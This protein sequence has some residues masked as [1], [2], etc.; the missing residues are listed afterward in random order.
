MVNGK[1]VR[2]AAVSTTLLLAASAC[3][4]SDDGGGGGDS[5]GGGGGGDEA[6]Q[7]NVY[8]SDGNMG[9]ALGEKFGDPGAIAG[10][11]G[12][13]PLT[14]LT[15]DF[16]SRLLEIDP[17]LIDFNY[18]AETYDAVVVAALAAEQARTNQATVFGPFV[19]GITSGG[20]K[21]TDFASCLAIIQAGGDVDFDG[22]SGPLAFTE[23]GEPA[24]ASF[25]ILTFGED[26]LVDNDLT[27]YVLGGDEANASTVA[28]PAAP[29]YATPPAGAPLVVGTLLPLTGNLAF[30]G[31]P[32]VAAAKLVIQDINAAGGALGQPVT[33]I[34]TDSGDT[35]TD[36]A[37]VSVDRLLQSGA[38]VIVGAAS[39]GVSKTVI[40]K[41]TG[42]GVMQI[43]PANTSDEFT[44][45]NDNGLYFR[46][47]P[48]DVLQAK[49]LSD[50]ILDDGNT[51]VSIIA[52]NDPYGTGLASN[53]RD[54]LISA[55]LSEESVPEV[56]IYDPAATSYRTEVGEMADFNPDAI[57]VIG[58]DE[59]SKIIEEMNAQGIGPAA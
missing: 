56:I 11:T 6:K 20:E 41:I 1:F 43:S 33:L 46:T 27:E 23:P 21:C 51:S 9:N 19:N 24:A 7:V 31:P 10:M 18:A 32:E 25:G 13:T 28:P 26:N 16:T 14:E 40:D 55:G 54:N 29:D 5:G 36:T 3:G 57:V 15:D 47:A 2:I 30:L 8:G 12:T 53:L 58:F 37:N 17:A 50:L 39:S 59:S 49:A 34:E 52:L 44:T 42:A 22:L 38:N 45:Y 48:P 35:S 4:G